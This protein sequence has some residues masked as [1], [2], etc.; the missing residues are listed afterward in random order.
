MSLTKDD[1]ERGLELLRAKLND[2]IADR[3]ALRARVVLLERVM[4]AAHNFFYGEWRL[5]WDKDVR[6]TN[7]PSSVA[8]VRAE[9]QVR[10]AVDTALAPSTK[11]D[12]Y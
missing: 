12:C 11:S 7:V 1:L 10:L 5:E 2:V 9:N 4:A 6:G 8:F 3:D